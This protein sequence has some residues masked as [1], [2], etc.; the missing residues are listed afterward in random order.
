MA[1]AP[2]ADQLIEAATEQVGLDDFG[3][4]GFRA[5]LDALLASF[6]ADAQPNA[7]GE[8][9]IEALVTGT[10]ATRLQVVDW[11]ARHPEVATIPIDNPV[12]VVGVSRSG[13]T[14]L[15]HLLSV[16]PGVRCPR[17]W[18]AQ[19]PIPPPEADTYDTDERYLAAIEA[20]ENSVIHMLNP[21]FKAMHH[22]PPNMPTE[23][24]PIMAGN[25][26]SLQFNAMFNLPGYADFVMATD[27]V[28]TYRYHRKVIQVLASRHPGRWILKTPHHALA[29]DALAEVYPDARFV[30]THRDPGTCI[31]STASISN[32]LGTTFSDADHR[33]SAGELWMRILSEMLDRLADARTRHADRF[34]DV[35]YRDLVADPVG[36]AR[37]LYDTIG[38]A[39]SEETE[40]RMRAHVGEHKQH[41]WGRHEY[42]FEDFGLDAAALAER[43]ADY[44]TAYGLD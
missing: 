27:H 23:C 25:M 5:G 12:F 36:T 16:D 7:I 8:P 42:T 35:D 32:G 44:R 20:D 34:I 31:A 15:H 28:D 13:T 19:A 17:Q 41:R 40:A 9:T 29:V 26:V 6:A 30:W 39:F 37:S 1:T 11:I 22:D 4:D 10:L 33:A 2:S 18:E 38:V 14:A 3:G 24:V 43:H 21:G